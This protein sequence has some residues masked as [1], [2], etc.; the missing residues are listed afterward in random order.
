MTIQD[1]P[2]DFEWPLVGHD[3]GQYKQDPEYH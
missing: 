2:K 3:I 1:L